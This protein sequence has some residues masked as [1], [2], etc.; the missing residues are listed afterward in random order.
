MSAS[1]PRGL[2][3]YVAGWS[4][5]AVLSAVVAAGSVLRYGSV[6]WLVVGLLLLALVV[7]NLLE[8]RTRVGPTMES[9]TFMEIAAVPTMLL[10]DPHVAVLVTFAAAVVSESLLTRD[11]MKHVFNVGWQVAAMVVGAA[12]YSLLTDGPFAGTPA[13][14]AAALVASA[15][16]VLVNHLAFS[17]LLAIL[18]GRRVRTIALEELPSSTRDNYG[19][20]VIGVLVG[21]LLEHVAIAVPLVLLLGVML[22]QRQLARSDGYERLAA[23]RDRLDRTV[24]GSSDGVVLLEGS[25]RVEVWNPAMAALTGVPQ[26]RAVG[27]VLVDLGWE[28]LLGSRTDADEELRLELAD[29]VL[30]V[31]C[32]VVGTGPHSSTVITVRD[33]SREAELTRIRE[34]LVMRISHELRTPLT[35]LEGFLEVLSEHWHGLDDDG[36]RELVAASRRGSRRL[37]R[38]VANLMVWAGIESRT[39][40]T[41]RDVA[42]EPVAVLRDALDEVGVTDA[43]IEIEEGV[44]VAAREEDVR[45]ILVNLLSN[46]TLY[47]AA[48]ID[49]AVRRR[50]SEVALVVTDAG[51]G[52]PLAFQARSFEPFSQATVGLQRTAKGLG[53]GLAIVRSLAT[54]NGGDVRYE[55]VPLGGAR[56]TVTLPAAVPQPEVAAGNRLSSSSR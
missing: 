42:T 3:R 6:P 26:E 45:T 25:G 44:A 31:R 2:Q 11:L 36:R 13:Q 55:D 19:A 17:G 47:G 49:V 7:A 9:S 52:L 51:P 21:V 53:M 8:V 32:A 48:P 20:A 50:G 10:L 27:A 37:A 12:T 23:E 1:Y 43:R 34:D 54:S 16:F 40:D 38:L 56:F 18:S 29:G 24:A 14:V 46:A 15:A 41:E 33:V 28:R 5:V 39:G 22:R 35:S 4:L 30:A